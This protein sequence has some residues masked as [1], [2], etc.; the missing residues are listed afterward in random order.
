M[1]AL[2]KRTNSSNPMVTLERVSRML[3]R[4]A[5]TSAALLVMGTIGWLS[6]HAFV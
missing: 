5:V 4:V 1:A 6:F 3:E 2:Q